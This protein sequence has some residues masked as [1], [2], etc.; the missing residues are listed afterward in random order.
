M[1][2]T[3]DIVLAGWIVFWLY[4]L[5]SAQSVKSTQETRGPL[6]GNWQR[7]VLLI[8]FLF[9]INFRFLRRLG[10]PFHTLAIPLI[11]QT[12]IVNAAILILM[13][14]GLAV[15]LLARRT[16]AGNWSGAVALKKDHELITTGLYHYVRHPIYTGILLMAFATALL[17]GTF[18]ACIGFLIIL[19]GIWFKL[20][21]EETLLA[22]HFPNEY[23]SYKS[24]TKILIPF[25]W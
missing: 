23:S 10:G 17:S 7:I 25:L 21:E 20:K 15:A 9:M 8:G 5:I 24:Q 1:I 12:M 13:S 2:L 18:S 11:P 19:L 4:W 16:L 3:E 22:K 14:A 6:S